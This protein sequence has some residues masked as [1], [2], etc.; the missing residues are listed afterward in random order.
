MLECQWIVAAVLV[1]TAIAINTCWQ[2]HC[3]RVIERSILGHGSNYCNTGVYI[4][5]GIPLHIDLCNELRITSLS[6]LLTISCTASYV[7]TPS[8]SPNLILSPFRTEYRSVFGLRVVAPPAAL[9]NTV[10]TSTASFPLLLH[11]TSDQDVTI[12][13][14]GLLALFLL[15]RSLTKQMLPLLSR[16]A[17][18]MMSYA[19]SMP[20][21]SITLAKTTRT[22]LHI[23]A[24][25]VETLLSC[26]KTPEANSKLNI[27]FSC[28]YGSWEQAHFLT[29]QWQ[30]RV[31]AQHSMQNGP[32]KGSPASS[33]CQ[34][35]TSLLL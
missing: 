7:I 23:A 19:L 33:S 11:P 20:P 14:Q 17:N 1:C 25:L 5:A 4:P 8:T 2:C 26:R 34:F 30:H 31:Y 28:R 3:H 9:D 24:C 10:W 35:L 27:C 22:D 6:R 13:T 18:S 21:S 16:S 12:S 32:C 29:R 15:P